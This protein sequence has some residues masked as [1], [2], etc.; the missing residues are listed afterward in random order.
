[1]YT[2]I[3]GTV[4]IIC[5]IIMILLTKKRCPMLGIGYIG[6][7]LIVFILYVVFVAAL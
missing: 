3:V 7:A 4:A 2:V 5:S 6:Y 1:M